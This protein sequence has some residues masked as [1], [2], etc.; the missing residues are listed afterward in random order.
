MLANMMYESTPAMDRPKVR[1]CNLFFLKT[2]KFNRDFITDCLFAFS[3]KEYIL[4]TSAELFA[5]YKT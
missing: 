2:N 4:P 1:Y 3:Q 5:V